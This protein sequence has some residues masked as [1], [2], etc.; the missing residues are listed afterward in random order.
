MHMHVYIPCMH[1]HIPDVF[2]Y[3]NFIF[4]APP[5]HTHILCAQGLDSNLLVLS[6]FSPLFFFFFFLDTDTFY[7]RRV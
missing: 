1:V 4:Y 7:A 5:P 6:F 3:H 2:I